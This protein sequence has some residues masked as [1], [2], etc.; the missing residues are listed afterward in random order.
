MNS[1]SRARWY[2]N[3]LPRRAGN[4]RPR[5]AGRVTCER[6]PGGHGTS[7][8][9]LEPE[10]Y[11]VIVSAGSLRPDAAVGMTMPHHWTDGGVLIEADFT[12]AHLLHLAAAGCVLNDLYRESARL[13][14]HLA[15]VRVRAFGSFD[16]AVWASTGITYTV[17]LDTEASD[18]TIVRLLSDVDEVAEIPRA[19]RKGI[20][21]VRSP[22]R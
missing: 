20:S 18:D 15:G 3:T 16:T 5:S 4:L 21:V 8:R 17:E 7:V 14:V 6:S 1:F 9:R 12:G 22:A 19:L 11:D 2:R 13:G 10:Q